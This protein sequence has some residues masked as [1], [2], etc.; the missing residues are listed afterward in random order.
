MLP[1]VLVHGSNDGGWVWRKLAP[2]LRAA[3]HLVYT[4]TLTGLADRSHLL[5]CGVNLTTHITDVVNLLFYEDLSE[6]VLVGNSYAGMVITG[7]AAKAPE[8]LKLLVYLDA[9]VP[10]EGQSEFDLLP[11]EVRA[12]RQAD[13]AAHGGLLQSPP[14]AVF[15]ITDPALA[16]WI[17][18]R[19]TPH[20]VRTYSEPV[21]SGNADSAAIP[22]VF[23]RC[24]F[25]PAVT[26]DLFASSAAKARAK[27]WQ[28]HE[29]AAG[30]LA[31]LT[32]P[33][34]VAELLLLVA[35]RD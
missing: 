5:D 20:P 16:E 30:H 6:V 4:P 24:T 25:N 23:I 13:A 29:L 15:G 21:P 32:A 7:V 1:F 9:Y 14:P 17:E 26:P 10:D 8:R 2:L 28:V 27:G 33:R 19:S 34:E 11:A 35:K 18:A 3:G 12:A 31:M 22:R